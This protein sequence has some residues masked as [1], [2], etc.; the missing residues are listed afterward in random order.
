MYTDIHNQEIVNPLPHSNKIYVAYMSKIG[1]FHEG[2]DGTVPDSSGSALKGDGILQ[3]MMLQRYDHQDVYNK[4]KAR[5]FV[6]TAIRN[7]ALE[8]IGE[9]INE[10][11]VENA[12]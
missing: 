5:D 3:T 1:Y 8:R 4:R 10:E 9:G 6:I 7:L 2:G 12:K 11:G